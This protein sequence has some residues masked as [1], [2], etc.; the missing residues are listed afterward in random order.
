MG[1]LVSQLG[2]SL[3]GTEALLETAK[4]VAHA[5]SSPKEWQKLSALLEGVERRLAADGSPWGGVTLTLG[6]LTLFAASARFSFLVVYLIAR[7]VQVSAQAALLAVL[8]V[9]VYRHSVYMDAG[10]PP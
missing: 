10:A 2:E 9:Y 7:A 6:L 4:G 3:G 5:A 8:L 1:E